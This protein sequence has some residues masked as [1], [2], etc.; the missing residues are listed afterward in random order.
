MQARS[1]GARHPVASTRGL[2][3]RHLE[4][5]TLSVASCLTPM[6]GG[7]RAGDTTPSGELVAEAGV[8]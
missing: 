2:K 8:S 7:N 5:T 6:S 4:R 1:R 3:G